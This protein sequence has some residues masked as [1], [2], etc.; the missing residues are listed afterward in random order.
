MTLPEASEERPQRLPS[1]GP[2]GAKG[3]SAGEG[4]KGPVRKP[5]GVRPGDQVFKTGE[6]TGGQ[7]GL[8]TCA[9][10]RGQAPNQAESQ[11]HS[12]RGGVRLQG[13][14]PV[15][16]EEVHGPHLDPVALGVVHQGAGPIEPHGLGV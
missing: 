14:V 6:G 2:Q 12:G 8:Q 11:T 16:E 15:A 3:T 7:G 9:G 1:T 10:G 13:T 5:R 4:E